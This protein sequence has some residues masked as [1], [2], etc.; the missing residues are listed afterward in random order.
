MFIQHVRN[1]NISDILDFLLSSAQCTTKTIVR[2]Q[3]LRK[4]EKQILLHYSNDAKF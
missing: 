3:I 2:L 1:H 4:Y